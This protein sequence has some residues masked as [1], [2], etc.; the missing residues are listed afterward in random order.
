MA[1]D[2]VT[3]SLGD[4]YQEVRQTHDLVTTLVAQQAQDQTTLANIGK[5]LEDHESRI[6]AQENKRFDWKW[7]GGTAVALLAVVVA[8]IA[9]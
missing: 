7:L 2:G 8:Y 1:S 4:I 3:V 6:R 5:T 9:R